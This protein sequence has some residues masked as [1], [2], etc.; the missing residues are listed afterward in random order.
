MSKIKIYSLIVICIFISVSI[1]SIQSIVNDPPENELGIATKNWTLMLYFAADTRADEVEYTLDNSNN[2]L[3]EIMA[4]TL[5]LLPNSLTAGSLDDIN[6]IILFDYPYSASYPKGNAKIFRLYYTNPPSLI[7]SWGETNMGDGATLKN[8]IDFCKTNYPANNYALILNDHGRAYAGFCYDYHAPHPYWAYALGDCLTV[9]EL[10]SSLSLA[11]GVD[12]LIFNTCSGGS[13]EVAWQLQEEVHYIIAGEPLQGAVCLCHALDVVAELSA[14]PSMSPLEFA[15]KCYDCAEDVTRYAVN[16][17]NPQTDGVDFWP[18]VSLYDLE[19]FDL[20]PLSASFTSIFSELTD[21]LMIEVNNGITQA[22]I[23]FDKIRQEV[24][25]SGFGT[26]GMLIDLYDF[27]TV[28]EGYSANFTNPNLLAKAT[29]VK[30]YI[31]VDPAGILLDFF[32]FSEVLS[33]LNGFSIC[34]PDSSDMYKGY[35]YG[36]FYEQLDISVETQWEE[37]I[38]ALYPKPLDFGKIPIPE[39]YEFWLGPIDPTVSLHVFLDQD[40]LKNPLHV[41]LKPRVDFGMGIDL[42]IEG[43]E[44]HD[45]LLFGRTMIRIPTSSLMRS[46]AKDITPVTMRIVVNTTAAASATQPVNLT[47]RH[48]E[49]EVLIWQESKITTFEIGT[50]LIC[51][52]STEDEMT[53][54]IPEDDKTITPLPSNTTSAASIYEFTPIIFTFSSITFTIIILEVFRKRKILK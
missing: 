46:T 48:V 32:A 15:Q 5:N 10:E 9:E 2:W 12:V 35:L 45:D 26:K 41:G 53:D 1:S 17:I 44:F 25:T 22:R 28:L 24:R 14:D 54:L 31:D 21:E 18:S 43:A 52:V 33:N 19:H 16:S 11:G 49:N 40:P 8:F 20:A 38:F 36:N 27:L 50:D 13:F 39:F 37:F 6:V 29:Q 30:N 34:F 3:Y 23:L 47:V 51:E 7:A 42:G 4:D